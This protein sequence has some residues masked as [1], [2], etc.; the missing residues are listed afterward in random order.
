MNSSLRDYLDVLTK[1]GEIRTVDQPVD[2]RYISSLAS[3]TKKGLQFRNLPGYEMSV[4]TG[5][6]LSRKRLAA[7]FGVSSHRLNK[8]LSRVVSGI[9][10]P[11]IVD[12]A[13][14]MQRI[15]RHGEVDLSSLPLP[16]ESVEDGAPYITSGVT[17][18]SDPVSGFN[19]GIYRLMLVDRYNLT[20]NPDPGSNLY[21]ILQRAARDRC[22]AEV[23]VSIGLHPR[24]LLAAAFPAPLG[25]NELAI[26][27]AFRGE[28]L[29]LRP[30]RT[31]SAP[32]IANAEVVLEGVIDPASWNHD[33]GEV[34]RSRRADWWASQFSRAQGL[35]Y[36]PSA[37]RDCTCLAY[38][39]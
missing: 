1:R 7:A 31:V 5:I 3:C 38:A 34:R 21:T 17:I 20:I 10:E 37:R 12:D 9:L 26:A 22:R 8:D 6:L 11:V 13:P 30:G 15:H 25:T 39:F 29:E 4:V 32:S 24:D 36:V 19:A 14:V 18:T 27:G 35:G 16:L 28:P 23:S 33:E 2:P